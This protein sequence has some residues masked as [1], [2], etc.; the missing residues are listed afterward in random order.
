MLDITNGDSAAGTLRETTLGGDV[1]AWRD[2]LNDGPVPAVPQ[3][4]LVAP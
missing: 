4:A 2:T 3:R 1:L